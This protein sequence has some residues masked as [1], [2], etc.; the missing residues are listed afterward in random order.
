M[1]EKKSAPC[2]LKLRPVCWRATA[3]PR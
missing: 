3:P 2:S 1:A